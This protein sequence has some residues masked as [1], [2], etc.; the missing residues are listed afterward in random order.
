VLEVSMIALKRLT[1]A[2]ENPY[3]LYDDI[4]TN[5]KRLNEKLKSEPRPVAKT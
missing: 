1:R 3:P 5:P 4:E 2:E